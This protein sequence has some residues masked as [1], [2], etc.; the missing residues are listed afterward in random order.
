LSNAVMAHYRNAQPC[1]DARAGVARM[2]K[3]IL[4]ARPL[5]ER[6][7]RDVP[8][9]LGAKP[10]LLVWGMKD[11]AFKPRRNIPQMRAAFPD[12]VLVELPEANHYIQEDAPDRISEAI[13]DRFG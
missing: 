9:K 6:L 3:E 4:A 13:I 11:F 5:L 8:D 2:P 1:P 7:S 12:H 10:A